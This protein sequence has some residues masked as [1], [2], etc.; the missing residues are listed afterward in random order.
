VGHCVFLRLKTYKQMS[1]KKQNKDNKLAPNYYGPYK[2]FQ[3]IGSMTYK[4]ELPPSS[5]VHLVFCVSFLKKVI[6]NKIP[7]QNIFL[8]ISEEGKIVLEPETIM[9]TRIK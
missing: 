2:V 1:L 8:D 5:R 6:N 7:I 4:L 3:R 9:E